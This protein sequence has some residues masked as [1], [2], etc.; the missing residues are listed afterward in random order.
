MNKIKMKQT[1]SE[2]KN[3]D[4]LIISNKDDAGPT[5]ISQNEVENLP[6]NIVSSEQDSKVTIDEVLNKIGFTRYHTIMMIVVGLSLASDGV[7]LYL[8]YLISPVLKDIYGLS[9]S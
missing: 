8:I 3:E 7:E 4:N 9:D 2:K 6:L 5:V 1:K